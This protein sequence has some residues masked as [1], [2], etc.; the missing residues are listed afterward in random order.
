MYFINSIIYFQ[1]A[2]IILNVKVVPNDIFKF[3]GE[4]IKLHVDSISLTLSLLYQ[5]FRH[6]R[7][8]ANCYNTDKD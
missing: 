3:G 2:N 8:S 7:T 1:K 5:Q 6:L 4:R